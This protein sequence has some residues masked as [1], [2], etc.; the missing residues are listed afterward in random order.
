ME[1]DAEVDFA[2]PAHGETLTQCWREVVAQYVLTRVHYTCKV[3]LYPRGRVT[4]RLTLHSF[5]N[6][7]IM[8]ITGIM[9]NSGRPPWEKK[10][11]AEA[12][13]SSSSNASS[14][15]AAAAATAAGQSQPLWCSLLASVSGCPHCPSPLQ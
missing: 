12:A 2:P 13:A 3:C 7:T 10:V 9:I 1:T 5:N 4:L 8:T 11:P 15:V 14:N 6:F